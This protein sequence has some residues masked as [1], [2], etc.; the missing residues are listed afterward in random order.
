MSWSIKAFL[1]I[2]AW[3]G[4]VALVSMFRKDKKITGRHTGAGEEGEGGGFAGDPGDGSI[5]GDTS[6]YE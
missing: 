4:L 1:F 3:I 2:A 5:S 6:G